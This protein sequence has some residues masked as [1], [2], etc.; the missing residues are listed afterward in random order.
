MKLLGLLISFGL[1]SVLVADDQKEYYSLVI[2]TSKQIEKAYNADYFFFMFIS[3]P[4]WRPYSPPI[5]KEIQLEAQKLIEKATG[6]KAPNEAEALYGPGFKLSDYEDIRR[7]YVTKEVIKHILKIEMAKD[8]DEAK[9]IKYF[10]DYPE[11]C[12]FIA[13]FRSLKNPNEYIVEAVIAGVNF[14]CTLTDVTGNKFKYRSLGGI[15]WRDKPDIMKADVTLA[16]EL[17]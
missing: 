3:I 6:I 4:E 1:I 12:R 13:M 17:D 2:N 16:S 15:I 7:K 10:R 5:K 9:P 14:I 11:T 8:A